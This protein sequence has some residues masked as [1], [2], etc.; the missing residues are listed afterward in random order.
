MVKY[1]TNKNGKDNKNN[2]KH[3]SG[4]SLKEKILKFL[5][6]N[7][8][9]MSILQISNRLG[10]DYKNTFQAIGRYP[11]LIIRDKKGNT[12]FVE[13]KITSHPEIY[14]VE[15]KRTL[16]FLSENK[17]MNL[18][19]K[20]IS[21]L[22]Y[23]FFIVVVFGS[24]VKRTNAKGSDIDVCI[25]SDNE[26]KTRELISKL[27]LLPLNLEIHDFSVNEFES[28]LKT[29]EGNI[30]K[31]IIKNNI[32]LYGAENYYNLTGKWMKKD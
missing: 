19:K 13:M 16:D 29:R 3:R 22:N 12:N 32:I 5:I 25:I 11:D 18:A 9:P 1:K 15:S 8:E 28:M 20:D 6:E 2:A 4:W 27:S 26:I 10:A 7:K 24:I 17:N 14:S 31:E 23:P 21:S 30:A